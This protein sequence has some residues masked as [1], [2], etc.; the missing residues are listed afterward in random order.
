MYVPRRHTEIT[1]KEHTTIAITSSQIR[2]IVGGK[3][4]SAELRANGRHPKNDQ[5]WLLETTESVSGCTGA[6]GR[7]RKER[8]KERRKMQADERR[9][10]ARRNEPRLH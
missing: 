8:R 4:R 5:F 2:A 9:A 7:R 6:E 1:L 3:A 10:P